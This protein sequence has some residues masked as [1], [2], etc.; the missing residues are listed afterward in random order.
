ME[1]EGLQ[2]ACMQFDKETLMPLYTLKIGEVGESCALYIAEKLGFPMNLLDIAR[3][4]IYDEVSYEETEKVRRNKQQ[5]SI[6]QN[7][8]AVGT[9]KRNIITIGDSVLVFPRK[10]K[11]IVFALEN[12]C[13]NIVREI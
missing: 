13:K 3:I 4:Y 8:S 6:G 2:N 11:G 12:K 7:Q 10:E 1:T 5:I 9:N